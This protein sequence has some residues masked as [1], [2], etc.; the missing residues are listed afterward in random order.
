[1]W[2]VEF[3]APWCG[4]CKSLEPHWNKVATELKG[5]IKVA[6]LDATVHSK[7]AGKY[8]VRGY[9]TIKIFPPTNKDKP[10]EYEGP[11]DSAAIVNIALEKLEKYGIIPDVEQLT[12]QNQFTDI[13]QERTGVCVITFLPQLFD[14]SAAQRKA[15][16]EDIKTATKSSRGKPIYYLWAQGAD[17][18]DF[19]EK[20]GLSFGYPAVVAI[21]L[22]KKKYS[23]MR[24]AFN[25]DN[26]K[27]FVNSI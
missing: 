2:L 15:Y 3:Y 1:M 6:K 19:E 25:A 13:C 4:H 24:A 9:P 23:V 14:S 12:N 27:A 17:Y 20:L 16:V 10:E 26:L 5:K 7:V 21:N 8:G 11:R 18:F 22:G